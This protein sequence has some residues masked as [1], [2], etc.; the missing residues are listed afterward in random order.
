MS[1]WTFTQAGYDPKKVVQ[2]GNTFLCANGYMGYRGTLDEQG[3]KDFTAV[4][5][6]GFYDQVGDKWREPVNAPNPLGLRLSFNSKALGVDSCLVIAHRQWLDL[7]TATFHRE[8]TFEVDGAKLTL[9]STRFV[10]AADDH[11]LARRL[12]VSSNQPGTLQVE[13]FIDTDIWDINGPHLHDFVSLPS[14]VLATTTTG[15]HVVAGMHMTA[16][17]PV[18]NGT[19]Q[20]T[21][22]KGMNYQVEQV[23]IVATSQDMGP[24][25]LPDWLGKRWTT[26]P[27]F[28]D[29]LAAHQAV[30]AKRWGKSDVQ[31]TGDDDAQLA[32]R[33]SIY[34]LQSIAPHHLD[35]SIP[36][37]GLSG[38]TYKGAC[39]WD[40]EMFML[41]FFEATD[42]TVAKRLLNYRI[43]AL[44]AARQKAR[45]YGFEGAFYAWESQDGG[46]DAT[47]DYNVVSVFTKRPMRT[48]FKDKQ[49]HISAAVAMALWQYVQT[50]GDVAI[51]IRG[52]AEVL[53]ECAKFFYSR[54]VWIPLKRRFE[55][56]DV[57][58]P[59]E[60][61]ERVNNNLYTNLA[62]KAT[63]E[64]AL[65]AMKLLQQTDS[66]VA[67][68][69]HDAADLDSWNLRFE[70][71]I[72]KLWIPQPDAETSV[73]PQ[74]DGYMTLEDVDVTTVRS[75]LLKPNEYW[76]GAYGV[77]SNTQV[78]KQA[79]VILALRQFGYDKAIKQAN[80]AYYEP[81]T[82][83]GSSLS[84]ST[85]ALVACEID[86]PDW[87]YPFFMQ[88]ATVDLTGNT[89]QFAGGL[90]IGGTH[91]AANGGAWMAVVQ[92]FC[93]L[94]V[95]D[96]A[97]KVAPHLP[98][99]WQ[100]V[101]FKYQL[102]D[103]WYQVHVTSE[104]TE[105][106]KISEK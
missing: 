12:E 75:R 40:T 96:G 89:K 17:Q 65:A 86:Q 91:P 36:A 61:H 106:I 92:G 64:V 22:Q 82:E 5:L 38:Q 26:L 103:Q 59:D 14:G 43:N 51:L 94:T 24:K 83:H 27:N 95:S 31:I 20:I 32:L 50:S 78:I 80:F 53:L 18:A 39:F 66:R 42:P 37:R 72:Q 102:R 54:A 88:T 28:D 7:Y 57:L 55:L 47:S 99:N 9:K 73:I 44:P 8:T 68:R 10:S 49:I 16:S 97:L 46:V 21:M 104:K 69:I 63:V 25:A 100:A 105:I 98:K 52:G 58:G 76:G 6:M 81:R 19:I 85:Y 101:S 2:N 41:P 23:G 67:K 70:D 93:G 29:S 45:H 60:Y 33:Y 79:D 56:H 35:T 84:A 4:N 15:G 48:Y 30:W 1:N 34:Q 11:L 74:F 3:A 71:F 90:Y 13:G 77:A 62:A 87:A